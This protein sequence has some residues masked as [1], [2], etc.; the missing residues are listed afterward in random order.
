MSEM[1]CNQ[2]L[3]TISNPQGLSFFIISKQHKEIKTLKIKQREI[4]GEIWVLENKDEE[5]VGWDT[6]AKSYDS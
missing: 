2:N 6:Q 1:L 5:Q 3:F 4:R